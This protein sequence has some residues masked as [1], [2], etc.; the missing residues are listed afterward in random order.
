M[1]QSLMSVVS[2]RVETDQIP[3]TDSTALLHMGSIFD[4][5]GIHF[6]LLDITDWSW[7]GFS[8]VTSFK[9]VAFSFLLGKQSSFFQ[10][11]FI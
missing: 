5:I 3:C 2:E 10:N 9:L 4:R 6:E 7:W 8:N 11:Y 1:T